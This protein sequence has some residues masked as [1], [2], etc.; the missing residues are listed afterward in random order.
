MNKFDKPYRMAPAF[1]T[2]KTFEMFNLA[3]KLDTHE[4][5]QYSLINQVPF[6]ISDEDGNS[7]IHIV[8]T[9][10]SRKATHL[11]KLSV[12]KFLVH[13]GVNPDKPNKYNQTPLHLACQCQS[14]VI[15]EYLL[16]ID[17]NTN[18]NDN[19][20]LT[21]FHYLLT[22][23]IKT[24]YNNTEIIDFIPPPKNV[25]VK[26]YNELLEIKRLINDIIN[27]NLDEKFPIYKT[28]NETIQ[29][30]LDFDPIMIDIKVDLQSKIRSIVSNNNPSEITTFFDIAQ[31]QIKKKLLSRFSDLPK[32]DLTIHKTDNLNS[33]AHPTNKT[34]MS[35]IKNGKIKKVI[36]SDILTCRDNIIKLFEDFKFK[37]I[38]TIDYTV[39]ES[40]YNNYYNNNNFNDVNNSIRHPDAIDNAS[41]IINFKTLKYAFVLNE[42]VSII[43]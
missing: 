12:I 23:D 35:L 41:S 26:K 3:L 6:D 7:L 25:D 29:N 20:G 27:E 24:I 8:I 14:E 17:V 39:I 42:S 31:N 28:I 10:D 33:W 30:I 1:D 34:E 4:L 18:F 2:K 43:A 19:M 16:S 21:P 38:D 32:I 13:Q 9:I 40:E 5:L 11:S 36:K 37:K 15:V 22:G